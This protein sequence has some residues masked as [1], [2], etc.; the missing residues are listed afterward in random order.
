[1]YI[2]CYIIVNYIDFVI[3]FS[4]ILMYVKCS[5]I[6]TIQNEKHQNYSRITRFRNYG[7]S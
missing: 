6:N 4:V 5:F 1:M 3:L 2:P 7:I